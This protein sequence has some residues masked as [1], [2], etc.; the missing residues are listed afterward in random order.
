MTT[1]KNSVN[2]RSNLQTEMSNVKNNVKNVF[3]QDAK[4]NKQRVFSQ[5]IQDL[6]NAISYWDRENKSLYEQVQ[7][8]K[9]YYQ[10]SV[11]KLNN[12]KKQKAEWEKKLAEAKKKDPTGLSKECREAEKQLIDIRAELQIR[13]NHTDNHKKK[14][15]ALTKQKAEALKTLN[16]KKAELNKLK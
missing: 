4:N 10:E 9:L 7:T 13:Q 3:A 8:Q 12:L 5:E 15:D 1:A 2:Y 6:N 11:E 16:N 14:L